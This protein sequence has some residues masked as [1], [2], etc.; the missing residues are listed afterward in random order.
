VAILNT[1]QAAK[2]LGVDPSRV[3]VLIREGRLPA[4]KFGRDYMIQSKDLALVKVRKP[5]RPKKSSR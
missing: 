5:G 2:T 4:E 3:R 1:S